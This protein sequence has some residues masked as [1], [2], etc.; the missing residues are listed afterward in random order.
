MFSG[1]DTFSV[2]HLM[3]ENARRDITVQLNRIDSFQRRSL[4]SDTSLQKKQMLLYMVDSISYTLDEPHTIPIKKI[5]R[6][7]LKD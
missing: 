2:T 5:A 7:E 1:V 3:I 4:V 6:I